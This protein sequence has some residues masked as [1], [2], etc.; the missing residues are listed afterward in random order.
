VNL[1][2]GTRPAALQP[3]PNL[4]L[5]SVWDEGASLY[6]DPH[7]PYPHA[8]TVAAMRAELEGA[9]L[10]LA[11]YAPSVDAMALVEHG[12]AEHVSAGRSQVR[13][14]TAAVD[15][16]SEQRRDAEGGTGW[17]WMPGGAWKALRTAISSGPVAVV[18]PRTGY[19][20]A[21]ACAHCGQWAE[22]RECA[23]SLKQ[24]GGG[25]DPVCVA[26]GVRQQDWHC[27]QCQS[28]SLKQVRQGVERITEQLRSMARGWTVHVS[29]SAAGT[30]R[31]GQ[32]AEGLVVATPGAL[33]AVPGGYAH[34]VV[35]GATVPPMGELG[36][37]LLALRWWINVA[38]MVRSRRDGG[39]VTVVGSLPDTVSHALRGWLPGQCALDAYRERA[40]LG[41]PPARRLLYLR[42]DDA[43]VGRALDCLDESGTALKALSGVSVAEAPLG[44]YVLAPRG[45]MPGIVT[46]VRAL[47]SEWSRR[48]EGELRVVVDGPMGRTL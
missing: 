48:G 8:R 9:G 6:A 1:V 23:A 40:E 32:V 38:A 37:E 5:V 13:D 19:V 31:D 4:G 33:P 11:S 45:A 21:L 2:I 47:Q 42:G 15:V 46:Q 39:G 34:V 16:L 12:W 35:V 18:V 27:P 44:V 17:H 25:D 36:V 20:S 22:C 3:V 28:A 43:V 7:A 24:A 26:C 14:R 30:L 10:I 29:T 41:L